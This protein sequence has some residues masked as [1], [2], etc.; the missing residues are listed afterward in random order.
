[1]I[2]D[3][4]T[5]CGVDKFQPLP[6]VQAMMRELGI[7]KAVLAQHLGQYDNSYIASC[8][9]SS[10]QTLAGV[11]M[12]DALAFD[13]ADALDAVVGS[14]EFRGLRMTADMLVGAPGIAS[15]ALQ[16]GLN[17]VLYCPEGT[18]PISG[19]LPTLGDGPGR[20]VVTHLGSPQVTDGVVSR[21]EEVL[22]L[23]DDP[24]VVVTLS[25]AGMFCPTP[26]EPLWPLV[27]SIVSAFSSA[28]VMWASNFP[29]TGDA[30]A[31]AEDLRLLRDNAWGLD[32]AGLTDIMG[33]TA[34]RIWFTGGT[35]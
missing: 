8:V 19:V 9:R 22:R 27:R 23:A 18:G 4:Y 25:G 1:M 34:D 26:H 21:G 17:V 20:I 32:P 16:L 33:A 6:D 3:A 2:I 29:V 10:P 24:R 30:R 7:A 13:A 28:R 11:A 35:P 14:G 5:H 15:A 31:V 12:I